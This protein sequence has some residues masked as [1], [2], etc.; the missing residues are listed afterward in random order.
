MQLDQ[1]VAELSEE[2]KRVKQEH[3]NQ[4]SERMRIEYV[5]LVSP[6]DRNR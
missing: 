6:L 4:Q 5:T 2:L 1:K 3:D